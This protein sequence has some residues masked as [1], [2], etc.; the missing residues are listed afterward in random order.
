[1]PEKPKW[2]KATDSH[3]KWPDKPQSDPVL[4][5]ISDVFLCWSCR[6]NRTKPTERL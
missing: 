1:M 6:F 5:A 4:R 2:P 3:A